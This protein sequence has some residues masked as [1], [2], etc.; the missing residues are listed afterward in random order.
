ML[1]NFYHLLMQ[2]EN[3]NEDFYQFNVG[4]NE[5]GLH[6]KY[7]NTYSIKNL[8]RDIPYKDASLITFQ[9]K[10]IPIACQNIGEDIG[11][12]AIFIFQ[13]LFNL[14]Y[15][16]CIY[17]KNISQ[18]E[19]YLEYIENFY[20]EKI[21]GSIPYEQNILNML[22]ISFYVYAPI[23]VNLNDEYTFLQT[24]SETSFITTFK[25]YRMKEYKKI[26]NIKT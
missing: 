22:Q 10:K 16:E 7:L 14:V 25:D 5:T 23:Y 24:T 8:N 15:I 17:I 13:N 19:Y 11:E 3:P 2:T 4:K 18:F 1:G 26:L 9:N 6:F 21:K 12:N 20:I